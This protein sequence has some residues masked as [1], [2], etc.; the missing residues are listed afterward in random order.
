MLPLLHLH[1]ISVNFSQK[2]DLPLHGNLF[3]YSVWIGSSPHSREPFTLSSSYSSLLSSHRPFLSGTS[4]LEPAE[5]RCAQASSFRLQYFPCYVWCSKCSGLFFCTE[6]IECF[7]GMVSKFS[8]KSVHY[9]SGGS[10]C[11]LNNHTFY[12]PH[13]LHLYTY[14]FYYYY[15][16][17][18]RHFCLC[19]LE[20]EVTFYVPSWRVEDTNVNEP[21]SGEIYKASN[22]KWPPPVI[23]PSTILTRRRSSKLTC[24]RAV[25]C[26]GHTLL[27]AVIR[28]PDHNIVSCFQVLRGHTEYTGQTDVCEME[29]GEGLKYFNYALVELVHCWGG[30]QSSRRRAASFPSTLLPKPSQYLMT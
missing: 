19:C 23:D 28:K 12:V 3:F 8:L 25:H 21:S 13:Y 7:P 22:V 30:M 11:Y 20:L 27:P 10:S 26:R 24:R 17:H 5:I 18:N 9:H 4:P 29:R 14:S 16:H 6:C 2:S 15:C 1:Q